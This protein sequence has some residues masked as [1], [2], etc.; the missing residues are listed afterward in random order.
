MGNNFNISLT[1]SIIS[2]LIRL[3]KTKKNTLPENTVHYN[4]AEY[5]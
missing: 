3:G 1:V 5:P 2:E 4:P